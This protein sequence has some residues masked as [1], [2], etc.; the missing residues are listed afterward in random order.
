ME[1]I[2]FV[3]KSLNLNNKSAAKAACPP[4]IGINLKDPADENKAVKIA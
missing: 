3:S 2:D 1:D 4:A